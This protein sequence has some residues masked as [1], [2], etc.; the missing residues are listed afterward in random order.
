[1]GNSQ[2]SLNVKKKRRALK[3]FSTIGTIDH[4]NILANLGKRIEMRKSFDKS[5]EITIIECSNFNL[6]DIVR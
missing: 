2:G 3:K 1:M 4:L 6:K 5:E